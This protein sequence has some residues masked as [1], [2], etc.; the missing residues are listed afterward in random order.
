MDA[1]KSAGVATVAASGNEGYIDAIGSPAC[2]STAIS[3]GSVSDTTDAVHGFSNSAGFL[4]FLAPGGG[5][6]AAYTGDGYATLYG[7]S[8]ATPHVAAHSPW[9]AVKSPP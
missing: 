4:D 6:T 7:T 5:I 8:M 3:V 1:L 9:C 2:V